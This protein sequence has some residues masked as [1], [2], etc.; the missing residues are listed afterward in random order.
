M[1]VEIRV[2]ASAQGE[3][4]DRFVAALPEVGSRSAAKRLIESG[5]VTVEGR[6]ARPARPLRAGEL[7]AVEPSRREPASVAPASGVPVVHLDDSLAVIDK[8]AGVVVHPAASHRGPTLVDL[9][10][11]IAAGGDPRRP[12]IVHRLDKDTSG[13]MIVARTEAAHRA[14]TGAVRRREVGRRYTA[15][16]E[17]RPPSRSGT[18]DAPI[19]RDPTRPTRMAVAGRG[20][21]GARTHFRALELMPADTLV[22]VTLETGRTHQ[23]RAH[24]FAIGHPV[25]GDP[26]YGTAGR[27]GLARQFLHSTSLSFRHP[28]TGEELSFESELP[29]DLRVALETARAKG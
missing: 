29:A 25:C 7:V 15:L 10:G 11:G 3:R 6:P 9:L 21:R 20:A 28:K 12:G 18:I 24:F 23:I 4:L 5:A 26:R 22:A 1:A 14:L 8:P 19:G 2:P 13:L 17:G 27:H 16:V